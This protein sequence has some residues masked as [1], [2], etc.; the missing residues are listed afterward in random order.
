VSGKIVGSAAR[1][2]REQYTITHQFRDF[3][4]TIDLYGDVRCLV[5][6]PELFDL[7]PYAI[8]YYVSGLK[9]FHAV[10]P[11][12]LFNAHGGDPQ[13]PKIY[14]EMVAGWKNQFKLKTLDLSLYCMGKGKMFRIPNVKRSNGRYKVP[15]TLEELQL[16]INELITLSEQPRTI[17]PVEFDLSPA[18][19]LA[20]LYRRC[21]D[22]ITQK[23]KQEKVMP[24]INQKPLPKAL[25]PCVRYILTEGPK[26][27]NTTFNKIV[28]NLIGYFQGAG[29]NYDDAADTVRPFLMSYE[30]S[31]GYPNAEDRLKHFDSQWEYLA[32]KGDY[33]FKCSYI[34]G[35]GFPGNAFECRSCQLHDSENQP[36]K[37][38]P[39]DTNYQPPG[40]MRDTNQDVSARVRE[41]LLDEFNGGTF[42]ISDLKR[43]LGLNDKQYVAARMC[44]RRMVEQE[45]IQKHGHQLG[46]Y[47]V[48]DK[49]KKAIDWDAVEAKPSGLILPCNLNK[50]VTIRNGDM[51]CFAAFKNHS[52]SA[53]AI[54][55]VRA[56]LD[57]FKVHFFITEYKDR[58]KKRL[59]DFGIDLNHPNLKCYPLDKS[60]YI[61]D[62]IEPGKGVLNVIDHWPNLDNFYLIGKYQDE[63]HRVLEGAICIITH[64]K[65][66]EKGKDAVGGTFWRTTPT[67]AVTVFPDGKPGE[68]RYKMQIMKGKEPAPGVFGAEG[69]KLEYQLLG[70]YQFGYDPNGWKY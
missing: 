22:E 67:L 40:G 16:P 5:H 11:A 25:P 43:E 9:G 12:E 47:R 48:V 62:K 68:D 14:K 39:P 53:L 35:M 7:D 3:D 18:P 52:K 55:S 42:R 65:L 17:E 28:M 54:E 58:V 49:G 64:Q 8:S 37:E 50:I 33:D 24:P 20:D 32:K 21:K 4:G 41:Y 45:L 26:S 36:G 59:L 57:N 2:R 23:T 69:K 29:R 1:S 30:H 56:N 31:T 44:V 66:A 38:L 13:L 6:L 19:D 15:L 10:I 34:L 27:A 51:I 63:I 46:S 70:G 60:D 61:P